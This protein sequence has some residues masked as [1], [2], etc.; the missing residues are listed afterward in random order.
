MRWVADPSTTI[1]TESLSFLTFFAIMTDG[2]E[3]SS[4]NFQSEM[5]FL[6]PLNSCEVFEARRAPLLLDMNRVLSK[7]SQQQW[8]PSY[9]PKYIK[10]HGNTEFIF[11][12]IMRHCP[13]SYLFCSDSLT[14]NFVSRAWLWLRL[15]P[16]VKYSSR[17]LF[18][19]HTFLRISQT[20]NT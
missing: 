2:F 5:L 18:I 9:C 3:L 13:I 19:S 12:R 20:N 8:E 11:I 7:S 15:G 6:W 4:C 17:Y 14:N 1:V 16:F 10:W